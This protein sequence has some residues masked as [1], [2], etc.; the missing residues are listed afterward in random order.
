MF[1]CCATESTPSPTRGSPD[2]TWGPSSFGAP[3]V[4]RDRSA[5]PEAEHHH[6]CVRTQTCFHNRPPRLVWLTFRSGLQMEK[7]LC[8][9]QLWQRC[10][11]KPFSVNKLALFYVMT[12]L[13][14]SAWVRR[15]LLTFHQYEML[16]FR[17]LALA[18]LSHHSHDHPS[19]LA[20]CL[21][22]LLFSNAVCDHSLE[23]V[24][25]LVIQKRHIHWNQCLCALCPPRCRWTYWRKEGL[26]LAWENATG[27]W[28]LCLQLLHQWWSHGGCRW[29]MVDT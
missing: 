3:S 21:S 29:N 7:A 15:D 2:P 12:C 26:S 27:G 25:G 18:H 22:Q 13:S 8:F 20:F 5:L 17:L 11:L 4:L 10:A 19:S 1:P 6:L 24:S 14:L 9:C 16:T 28:S 23:I